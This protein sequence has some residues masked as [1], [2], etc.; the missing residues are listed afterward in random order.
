[1]DNLFSD[2]VER[3][4]SEVSTSAAIRAIEGGSDASAMWQVFE[5][6]GFLDALVPES[7]DGAGLTLSQ[8]FPMLTS[9]GRNAV[10][11]PFA[12]TMLARAWL[13]AAGVALPSGPITIA[14]L[15]IRVDGDAMEGHAV[16]F[17]RVAHWV[18]ADL[19]EYC[20]LLPIAGASCV[21]AGGYASLS[22][23]LRWEHWP[24]GAV[25]IPASSSA[26]IGLAELAATGYAALLAGAADRVLEQTLNYANQRS[27]F[28]KHIGRFQAIQNQISVMAERTWA[29]RMAA[30]L[31]CES[32]DWSPRPL[33]SAVG[34]SRASE[35]A[36]IIADIAHAVHGAIGVTE[37]YDLQ[38][39]TRRLREWRLAGGTET[40][41]CSRI[42]SAL[43]A[44]PEQ[45]A[46]SFI[47]SELAA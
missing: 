42:G 20:A 9:A 41:W 12:H 43:L 15:G 16:A 24:D 4:L 14:G 2:S 23:A 11:L 1:M 18:L 21:A 30:Q 7:M 44:Q 35:A 27:Q 19:G 3:L 37:E 34:K 46:L 38:L 31:A 47:C 33:L 29:T 13:A 28:G 6:S 40:Y 25:K 17:G 39:Y 8:V 36:P 10:P 45:S 5:E 26:S 22:A 32:A